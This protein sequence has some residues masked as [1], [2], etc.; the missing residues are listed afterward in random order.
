MEENDWQTSK[1][2]S[3][4]GKKWRRV[5][6]KSAKERKNNK[7]TISLVSELSRVT[8]QIALLNSL[9]VIAGVHLLIH[10]RELSNNSAE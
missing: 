4:S 1:N 8:G 9:R 3:S 6:E 2:F 10:I 5:E 7:W